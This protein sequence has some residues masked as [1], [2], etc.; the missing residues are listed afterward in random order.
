MTEF[1]VEFYDLSFSNQAS[2][3]KKKR[4]KRKED[5][6]ADDTKAISRHIYSCFKKKAIYEREIWVE[7]A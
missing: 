6:L 4:K 7:I 1:I 5:V 2:C 3:A